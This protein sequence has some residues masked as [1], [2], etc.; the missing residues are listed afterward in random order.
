M[1]TKEASENVCLTIVGLTHSDS[2]Y[3]QD[4]K[5]L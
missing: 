5:Y 3:R 1:L 2:S 4:Y